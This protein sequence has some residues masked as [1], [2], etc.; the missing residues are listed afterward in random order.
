MYSA[1]DRWLVSPKTYT[2]EFWPG[3]AA[4]YS[5]VSGFR[6]QSASVMLKAEYPY[7]GR[8]S[9]PSVKLVLVEDCIPAEFC[10]MMSSVVH[11]R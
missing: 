3:G 1:E 10:D 7:G 8:R 9:I 6:V 11:S 5:P 2:H 4:S